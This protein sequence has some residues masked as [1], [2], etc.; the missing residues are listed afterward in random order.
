MRPSQN[1]AFLGLK[2]LSPGQFLGA[3]TDGDIIDSQ[4]SLLQLKNQL[5][6]SKIVCGA[7][8]ILILKWV[9]TFQ[10]QRF[11]TFYWTKI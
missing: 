5:Y 11:Q 8:V 4:N 1:F 3:S 10:N 7:F 9:M 6:G 2:N